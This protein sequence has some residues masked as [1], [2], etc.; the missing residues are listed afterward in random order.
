M[1]GA[2]DAVAEGRSVNKAAA[3]YG[4]P[5]TTLK[6]R[7]AGQVVHGDKPGPKYLYKYISVS[8]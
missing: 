5:R 3:D 1:K 8:K 6:D 7:L 4:V 2:M